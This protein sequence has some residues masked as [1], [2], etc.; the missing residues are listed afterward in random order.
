MS[1][2]MAMLAEKTP[3]RNGRRIVVLADMLELGLEGPK[4]HRQLVETIVRAG[5]DRVYV[6]GTLV[7]H[8]WNALPKHLRGQWVQ[9]AS[10][11]ISVL[12]AELAD[13][14]VVLFKGSKANGLSEVVKALRDLCQ[15]AA[16]QA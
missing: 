15:G 6:A 14:D 11:M 1:A 10:A 7:G 8:L 12:K 5:V 13:G 3:L 16:E 9:S 2:A 4:L